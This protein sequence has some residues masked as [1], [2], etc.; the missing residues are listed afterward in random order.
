MKVAVVGAGAIGAFA[1]AMLAKAG[2]DVTLVA[3]GPHL[4]A[5]QEHGVRVRGAVGSFD[6]RVTATDDRATIGPVEVGLL[7]IRGHSRTAMP[8]RHRH[9]TAPQAS[10]RACGDGLPPRYLLNTA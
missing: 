6:A 8:P 1:G 2:E 10:T 7:P 9:P 3:R 5:M 4:R